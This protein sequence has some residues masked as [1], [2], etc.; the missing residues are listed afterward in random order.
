MLP[1]VLF[2]TYQVPWAFC[3]LHKWWLLSLIEINSTTTLLDS[4]PVGDLK[5]KTTH[6]IEPSD[7]LGKSA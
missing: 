1:L 4:L 5:P 7:F 2:S 3:A 6:L